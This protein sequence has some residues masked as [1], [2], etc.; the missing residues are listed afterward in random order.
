MANILKITSSGDDNDHHDDSHEKL[1]AS[2]F[3]DASEN[4]IKK[5]KKALANGEG[6]RVLLFKDYNIFMDLL[7][8]L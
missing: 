2:G 8:M 7:L 1:H 4:M 3:D 6:C 5:V